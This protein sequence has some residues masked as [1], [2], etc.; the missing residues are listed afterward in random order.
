[1]P[2]V[3]IYL[4]ENHVQSGYP[5]WE[6]NTARLREFVAKELSCGERTIEAHEMSIRLVSVQGR[7]MIA[8][9]EIEI[10]AHAYTERIEK[11]DAT[12]LAIRT[13]MMNCV[14]ESK[15]VTRKIQLKDVQVW[16]ILSQLGHSWG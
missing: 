11:S 1:M 8:P 4:S 12:C 2:T 6:E 10:Q 16:L 15:K 9:I 7:G 5:V 14:N 13:Y 3:N